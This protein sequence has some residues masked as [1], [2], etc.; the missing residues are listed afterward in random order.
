MAE[1]KMKR[2]A[3][4]M[5]DI[6]EAK[7]IEDYPIRILGLNCSWA[8]VEEGERVL[9]GLSRPNGFTKNRE[10]CE[11][12]RRIYNQYHERLIKYNYSK[13]LNE[14]GV[15]T[16]N[17]L[18]GIACNDELYAQY[19]KKSYEVEG[20]VTPY[21]F[22]ELERAIDS[23]FYSDQEKKAFK[24]ALAIAKADLQE[25]IKTYT[26]SE[27]KHTMKHTNF[28][29]Y[30]SD[31]RAIYE[32]ARME[33]LGLMETLERSKQ[34]LK[35]LENDRAKYS[36]YDYI[37]EKASCLQTEKSV[38]NAVKELN[39]RWN[40]ST[41]ELRAQL[42]SD[43]NG[44]Y[45]ADATKLDTNT[46]TLLNSGILTDSELVSMAE[47]FTSNPT[48]FRLIVQEAKKREGTSNK[49]LANIAS[50]EIGGGMELRAFDSLTA[51]NARGLD[52]KNAVSQGDTMEA[53]Y[54]KI[55]GEC[56]DIMTAPRLKPSAD[57]GDNIPGA[58][59]QEGE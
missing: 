41:S 39:E 56:M 43:L 31:S 12:C 54:D 2:I 50:L 25:A 52:M 7:K 34:H 42:A 14:E 37:M 22:Q 23:F 19:R 57:Q 26:E 27:G 33:Y 17:M 18:G 5:I 4:V 40:K 9:K 48:M 15:H 29:D 55:F 47:S 30:L 8:L 59:S 10:F 58:S 11:D 53:N 13:G 36:E 38:E 45:S 20:R 32:G 49:A 46:L 16:H 3:G 28:T 24:E 51:W 1:P 35:D 21:T 6:E 44:F